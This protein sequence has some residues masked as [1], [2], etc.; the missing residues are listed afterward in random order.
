[1]CLF[2]QT[3]ATD[4][5]AEKKQIQRNG[6]KGIIS[7]NLDAKMDAVTTFKA[8]YIPPK[9]PGVRLRGKFSVFLPHKLE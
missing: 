2:T 9:S 8:T 6:H 3:T 1:M 5:K 4:L 7:M